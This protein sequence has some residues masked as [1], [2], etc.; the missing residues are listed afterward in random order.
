MHTSTMFKPYNNEV[1]FA[2]EPLV[3]VDRELIELLKAR[4]AGNER[5]RMRLCA[6]QD[7]Q[8]AL[9]EMFVVHTQETYVRPHK[10]PGSESF[11]VIEGL[12]DVVLLDDAGR[13]THVIRMGEYTSGLPFFHRLSQP[14]FH[15]LIIRSELIVFH[16]TKNGPF[17]PSDTAFPSWAPDG[18]SNPEEAKAYLERLSQAVGAVV[19]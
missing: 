13:V 11:H 10:H 7:V 16:E 15:T 2:S 3:R 17:Q 9:H 5:K 14:C 18:R 12:V 8:D 1:L 19:R 6:H 4:V